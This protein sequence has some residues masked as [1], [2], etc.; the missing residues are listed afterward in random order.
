L[1][2][3]ARWKLVSVGVALA[4]A[5][6]GCGSAGGSQGGSGG[7]GGGDQ[8]AQNINGAGSSFVAPFLSKVSQQFAK[9]KG[10]QV[11]Y[12][13][14]GSSGGREQFIQK[15]VSFGASDAPMDAEEEKQAGGSPKHIA[16]IGG[17]VVAAYN[18]KDIGDTPLN[19]TGPVLADIFLGKIKT[20][21]DPAI[22]EL[23]P[24]A[25]LPDAQIQVVHRSD[26]SGTTNIFTNYLSAI[27]PAWKNGPG[28]S[29]EL[30]WPVGIGADGNEG[31][32][33]QV[34][35]SPNS[36]GY[37]GLEYAAENDIKYANIGEKPG[38]YVQPSVGSAQAAI[39]QAGENGDIP[40]NLKVTISSLAPFKGDAYPITGLTWMLVR[41][42]MDDPAECKAV[43]ETAWY[44]THDGQALAKDL[45]YV[46]LSDSLVA[47]DEKFIKGMKAGGQ[48][49]YTG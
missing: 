8:A 39:E 4:V 33:G 5:A 35:Q 44:F 18:L 19:L 40:G 45:N 10:I 42:Q 43:A 16:V 20:W 14:I 36:I 9:D 7:G 22:A 15:S 6:A 28:P 47:T 38:K 27:S 21:S 3:V 41:Q 25:N 1:K 29:D 34:Q 11:N 24:N 37:V 2:S 46:E 13:S 31:V 30:D 32:A 12:Q 26:G 49:C 17:A 48:K 23:N